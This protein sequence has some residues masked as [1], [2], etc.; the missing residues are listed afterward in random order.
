MPYAG[1]YMYNAPHNKSEKGAKLAQK[2]GQ[3]QP[4]IALFSQEYNH[5]SLHLVGQPNTFVARSHGKDMEIFGC[6]GDFG[7]L[8][9]LDCPGP[10]GAFSVT[11][12][13][14]VE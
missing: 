10:L 3:L 7:C 11:T 8:G 1:H 12:R 4:F 14:F 6:A 2:L 13:T 9:C 5:G